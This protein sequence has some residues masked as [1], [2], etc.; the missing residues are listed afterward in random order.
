MIKTIIFDVGGVYMQGSF[1]D[2]VNKSRKILGV[3]EE[4][5]TKKQ[6][7]F[8]KKFNQGKISAE[9]CF[10]KYFNSPISNIQMKKIVK[11]WTTTWRPNKS[12]KDLIIKLKDNYQLAIL[13]NSDPLN[14]PNYYKKGWYQ[15]FDPIILSHELGILKPNLKIYK[16]LLKKIKSKPSECLFID[17]QIDCLKPAQKLGINTILY[18]S[19]AQLKSDLKK[20]NILI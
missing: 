6:V 13:S 19:L 18:K 12:M 2:F 10:K 16:T 4:F 15:Y 17:D 5:Y 14:S 3:N 11:I 8:D 7:T 20:F 9:N 1:I